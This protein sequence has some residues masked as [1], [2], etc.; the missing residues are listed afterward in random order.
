MNQRIKT[1]GDGSDPCQATGQMSAKAPSVK[2]LSRS[3]DKS[4]RQKNNKSA[5]GTK[6]GDLKAIQPFPQYFDNGA[7]KGEEENPHQ[8]PE[9]PFG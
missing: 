8:R 9:N 6:K 3:S 2:G 5:K 4:D 1:T 7:K